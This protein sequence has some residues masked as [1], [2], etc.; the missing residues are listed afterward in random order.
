[1]TDIEIREAHTRLLDAYERIRREFS[2]LDEGTLLSIYGEK[3]LSEVRKY[4]DGHT[5]WAVP[6]C[7]EELMDIL[8]DT[9]L[10]LVVAKFPYLGKNSEFNPHENLA[11][12]N[13]WRKYIKDTEEKLS[14]SATQIFHFLVWQNDCPIHGKGNSNAEAN[15]KR[16]LRRN[17]DLKPLMR[18]QKEVSKHLLTVCDNWLRNQ[19]RKFRVCE[20]WRPDKDLDRVIK[21]LQES[22]PS[23]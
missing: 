19:G 16:L 7:I 22:R 21:R 10:V 13:S 17:Q 8:S 23:Q 15:M 12:I 11:N 3:H 18:E 6:S 20:R 4:G 2:E 1:M 5:L 14:D 9:E